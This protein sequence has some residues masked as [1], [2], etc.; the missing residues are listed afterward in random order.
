MWER[1]LGFTAATP[2]GDPLERLRPWLLYL[3]ATSLSADRLALVMRRDRVP[4]PISRPLLISCFICQ[5]CNTLAMAA[6]DGLRWSTPVPKLTRLP[7]VNPHVPGPGIDYLQQTLRRCGG[8]NGD[9]PAPE[10]S[11][12]NIKERRD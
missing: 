3:W 9:R 6:V 7:I 10:R 8:G 11:F 2:P 5:L 1:F 4:T 12:P